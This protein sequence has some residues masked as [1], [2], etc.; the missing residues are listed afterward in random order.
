MLE[1]ERHIVES[2]SASPV[3]RAAAESPVYPAN[4]ELLAASPF[5]DPG[6]EDSVRTHCLSHRLINHRNCMNKV[7]VPLMRGGLATRRGVVTGRQA[8]GEVNKVMIAEGGIPVVNKV[9]GE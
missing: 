9:M 6:Y 2:E 5:T 7:M 4:P 1:N 8:G 3:S